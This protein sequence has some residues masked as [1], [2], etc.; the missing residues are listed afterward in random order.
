M[1]KTRIVCTIG[2]DTNSS[3][4]IKKFISLGMNVA[5]LNGSHNTLEWH[6]STI[7][8][9]RSA[10]PLIPILVDLPGRKIRTAK[11]D[12]RFIFKTL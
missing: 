2:P 8:S 4:D 12:H 6:R 3:E 10:D 5:R 1:K 7:K 11:V 9:I